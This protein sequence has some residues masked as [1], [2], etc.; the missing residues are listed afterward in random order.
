MSKSTAIIQRLLEER[1]QYEAWI[2]RLNSSADATPGNVRARVREDYEARLV[3]VM[4]EL[5]AHAESARLAIQEKR[6]TR[7]ELQKKEALAAEK[8]TETELRHSVGE[9]DEAQWE[10]VHQD[11]LAELVS[12]REDLQAVEADIQKLEELDAL[13]RNRP[14]PRAAPAP[15]PQVRPTAPPL[16]PQEPPEKA[17]QV[18][19]LE[20]IKSVTEDDTGSAPSPRRASGAQF[21]PSIPG[22][23]PRAAAPPSQRA[24]NPV[25]APVL[26]EPSAAAGDEEAER[27]LRCREC[28]TMNLPTEWYCGQCGAELAAV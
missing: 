14:T 11:V 17:A 18:D 1:R 19:E 21:Q 9:F 28:G 10:Q 22:D 2:A 12:V 8:L 3:A 27:T 6:H 7:G 20:F 5:K 26:P 24:A 25:P 16:L 13:V 15:A 4:E 23:P